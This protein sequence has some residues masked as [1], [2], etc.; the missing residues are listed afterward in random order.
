MEIVNMTLRERFSDPVT[1]LS[2]KLPHETQCLLTDIAVLPDAF[3]VVDNENKSIKR[4]NFQMTLIDSVK[5]DD[6]CGVTKLYLSCHVVVTQPQQQVITFI[7]AG[8]GG[9]MSIS[10][11]RHTNRKYQSVACLDEMRL[12]AGCCEVGHGCVDIL[13]FDGDVLYSIERDDNKSRIFRTPAS[14]T[15]FAGRYVLVSDSG[16]REL[17]CVTTKGE[18]KF[19]H[20]PKGTPSGLGVTTSGDVFMCVYDRCVVQ[21]LD[22]NMGTTYDDF[23]PEVET[24]FPLATCLSEDRVLVV[25]EEMPSDRIVVVNLDAYEKTSKH[26]PPLKLSN[27]HLTID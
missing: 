10:S 26:G 7:S 12:V 4:F 25:T 27:I 1:V 24:K 19:V 15:C 5:L 3:V 14:L 11:S 13:T 8:K 23:L 9:K 17:V 18:L 6:P 21:K 16:R 22:V 20:D 2:A